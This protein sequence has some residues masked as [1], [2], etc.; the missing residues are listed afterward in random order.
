MSIYVY[1]FFFLYKAKYCHSFPIGE[2]SQTYRYQV[3]ISMANA[4]TICIPH[5]HE[6]IAKTHTY[7][8]PIPVVRSSSRTSSSPESLLCGAN[9]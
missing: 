7:S 2:T 3:D 5:L 4:V 9:P 1:Q 6:F 8:L